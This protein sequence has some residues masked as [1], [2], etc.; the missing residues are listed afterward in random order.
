VSKATKSVK[1]PVQNVKA[2]NPTITVDNVLT[3]IG[4]E[5]LRTDGN[6]NDGG[7]ELAQRQGGFHFV[8]P[9]EYWYPG[10]ESLCSEFKSWDWTVGKTPEFTVKKSFVIPPVDFNPP[11]EVEFRVLKGLVESA[12]VT[13]VPMRMNELR[14]QE[15]SAYLATCQGQ[16]FSMDLFRN[17]ESVLFGR[18]VFPVSSVL[19]LPNQDP[20]S[21]KSDGKIEEQNFR[22][23]CII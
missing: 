16:A 14:D 19:S 13:Q 21:R 8:N 11:V 1:S 17:V 15:L 12:Q 3:A 22:Q 20:I 10:L 7:E 9:T 5:F 2:S 23:M 6:G 18:E 4:H